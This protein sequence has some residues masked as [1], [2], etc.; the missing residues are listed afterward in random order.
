MKKKGSLFFLS[1]SLLIFFLLL[2]FLADKKK[3]YAL[4]LGQKDL[5]HQRRQVGQRVFDFGGKIK[6][7]HS[8]YTS[9]KEKIQFRL[10]LLIDDEES[11]SSDQV[12]FRLWGK[13]NWFDSNFFWK[14]GGFLSRDDS[15][16]KKE[17]RFEEAYLILP[18]NPR[19][20]WVIGKRV[21][22]TWGRSYAW[23]PLG[24]V[25][26][27]RELLDPEFSKEFPQEGIVFLGAE[28]KKIVPPGPDPYKLLSLLLCFFLL[29][30]S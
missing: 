15:G 12:Y 7:S 19:L 6:I 28:Y 25:S 18:Y 27:P 26:Y 9:N 1:L 23:N 21:L 8:L 29:R 17:N 3:A 20:S 11:T 10:N 14:F 4:S 2:Y 13:H 30:I 5:F 22:T 16:T 24:F